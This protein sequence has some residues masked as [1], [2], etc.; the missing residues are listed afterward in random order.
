M[1]VSL[2][3]D[4]NGV[5]RNVKVV[6]SLDPGLDQKAIEA[7]QQWKFRPGQKDGNPVAVQAQIQVTF[8]LLDKPPVQPVKEPQ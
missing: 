3:V 4:E 7:V 1:L 8:K 6:R 2:V 5:P